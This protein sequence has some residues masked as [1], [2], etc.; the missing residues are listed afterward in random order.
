MSDSLETTR[1]MEAVHSL[2]KARLTLRVNGVTTR[3]TDAA[4][5]NIRI[6]A[7]TLANGRMTSVTVWERCS[8]P[9]EQNM[10][11]SLRKMFAMVKESTHGLTNASITAIGRMVNAVVMER[12]NIPTAVLTK[13]A[14]RTILRMETVF[15][16]SRTVA[17][18]QAVGK[19]I[20][21]QAE[22]LLPGPTA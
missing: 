11:E 21:S 1:C 7:L 16:N 4:R 14:S 5:C 13:E 12:S 17:R 3:R 2:G 22:A 9:M 8:G 18:I 20:L 6:E 15:S 10:K 19:M